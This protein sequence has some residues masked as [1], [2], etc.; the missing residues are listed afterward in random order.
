MSPSSGEHTLHLFSNNSADMIIIF[1]LLD[2]CSVYKLSE[3]SVNCQ[4][5]NVLIVG[6]R[7]GVL[8]FMRLFSSLS[9]CFSCVSPDLLQCIVGNAS[10]L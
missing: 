2:G 9:L 10:S 3:L 4:A 8:R 6:F 7:L 1:K 5:S